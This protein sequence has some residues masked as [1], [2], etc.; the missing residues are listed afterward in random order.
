M[1]E[2]PSPQAELALKIKRLVDER[3]WNQEEFARIARLNRHTVRQILA[4]SERRLRTSTI[5]ACARALGLTVNELRTLPL[6]KLLPRMTAGASGGTD[7]LRRTH[8]QA[9]QPELRAW[10]ERNP[11]RAR[12]LSEDELDELLSMQ[13][14]DGPLSAFGVEAVVQRIERRRRL[15]QQINTI[16]GTEYLDL[17]ERLVGLMYDKVRP[18]PSDERGA[19]VS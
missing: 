18:A 2:S 11:D 17:L 5:S 4:A 15:W 3:G 12:Q 19:S 1:Q 8:D 7:L 10:L 6:E 14:D 9:T 13:G 16:A